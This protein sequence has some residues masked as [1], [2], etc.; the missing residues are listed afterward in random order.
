MPRAK[1]P[2]KS[3]VVMTAE[4][5]RDAVRDNWSEAEFVRQVIRECQIQ[6]WTAVHFD[7]AK[8]KSGKWIT[9]YIGDGKGFPDII[10]FR[11][12]RLLGMELKVGH[13][14]PTMEQEEYL[15]VIRRVGGQAFVFWPKD[16]PH[17]IEV[18]A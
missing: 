1:K 12:A 4:E 18:L 2:T 13:N 15:E 5:Y 9:A 10:A 11:G 6:G 3:H 7:T 14:K 8:A 17:I 16:W